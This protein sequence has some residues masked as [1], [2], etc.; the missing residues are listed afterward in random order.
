M[1]SNHPTI[2]V[3]GN[4][5]WDQGTVVFWYDGEFM[6]ADLQVHTVPL[7]KNAG[8]TDN[9]L[10]FLDVENRKIL[11]YDA[12]GNRCPDLDV[13]LPDTAEIRET[14]VGYNILSRYTAFFQ[15]TINASI[16][17]EM[18][19]DAYFNTEPQRPKSGAFTQEG[20]PNAEP[21]GNS[22]SIDEVLS[23]IDAALEGKE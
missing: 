4:P 7:P 12:T 16:P 5:D 3:N 10:I 1:T 20:E 9:H 18:F 2:T 14:D 22:K 13:V 11:V 17:S 6:N 8:C 21:T 23:E 19:D 15:Y